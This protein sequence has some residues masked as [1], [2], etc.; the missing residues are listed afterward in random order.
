MYYYVEV[1]FRP[2]WNFTS[3]PDGSFLPSSPEADFRPGVTRRATYPQADL[4][5]LRTG[6]TGAV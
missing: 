4:P 1:F 3:Y 6:A 2:G 5:G